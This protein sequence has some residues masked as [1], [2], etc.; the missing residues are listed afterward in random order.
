M[1]WFLGSSLRVQG[2]QLRGRALREGR[3]HRETVSL[4]DFLVGRL[5]TISTHDLID[6]ILIEKRNHTRLQLRMS[7]MR[8]GRWTM[9]DAIRWT[10]RI[11]FLFKS[12]VA[13]DAALSLSSITA[14]APPTLLGMRTYV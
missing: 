11:G 2:S 4:K 6:R 9:G 12:V 13:A 14:Y 8:D 1:L 5:N 3:I 10:I 7:Y